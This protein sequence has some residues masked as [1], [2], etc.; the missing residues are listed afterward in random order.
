MSLKKKCLIMADTNIK[1]ICNY[2]F[3]Y[4]ASWPCLYE[5]FDSC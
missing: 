5:D 1:H 4:M 2:I 3:I